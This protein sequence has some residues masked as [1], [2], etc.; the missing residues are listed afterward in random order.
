MPGV[1]FDRAAEFYDAT[2]AYPD[3]VAETIRDNVL[4]HAGAG[5]DSRF[6]E[7]GVG[8]GRIAIPFIRA[9][10]DY[11]GIDLSSAMLAALRNK[12][13]PGDR[14]RGGFAVA[15]AMSLPFPSGVFDVVLMMHVLHLVDDHRETLREAR[16]TLRSGGRLIVSCGD[17][18]EPNRRDTSAADAAAGPRGV[19]R[20]WN[21]ILTDLGVD[22]QVRPRGQWL[23]DDAIA[24][25][26]AAVGASVERV[27]LAR[28]RGRPHTP[29]EA[30]AAHRNQVFSSDWDLP[31]DI[32]AEASRRLQQWLDTE[33]PSP[34]MSVSEDTEF[35][36]MVGRFPGPE[37][38]SSR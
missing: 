15:D 36:A 12:L 2:R 19:I 1:N 34:D 21:A 37:A 24:D 30:V 32:H 7:V 9:G 35:A 27:V 14:R 8:T 38:R 4:R 33:H 3:G 10:W 17:C 13:D 25:S 6:L 20:R 31:K 23:G 26:L 29:R 11:W 16:R 5:P 22:R 18:T 28:Y